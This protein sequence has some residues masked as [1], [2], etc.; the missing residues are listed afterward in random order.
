MPHECENC[1]K[2]F[3]QKSGLTAHLTRIIP[4]K[5]DTSLEVLI[6][7]K[8]K[9]AT[10]PLIKQINELKALLQKKKPRIRIRLSTNIPVN[11]VVQPEPVLVPLTNIMKPF[12]KWVGGKTQILD[13]VLCLYPREIKS[14]HEPFLGG[15]SVLLGLLSQIKSAKI[16]VNGTIYASDLNSNLIALY[17]NIQEHCEELI[18]VLKVRVE[19]FN[20]IN[21]STVN[22]EAKS[23]EE[24]SGSQ[25]SFYYFTRYM[26]NKMTKEERGSIVGSATFIF[27]NKTCFRGVYRES[28]NGGFN[29]PFGHYKN[30]GILDEDHMRQ[31]SSLVKDVVF[32]CQPFADSLAKVGPGDFVYLDPPYAP[33]NDKSFVAYTSDG[34]DLKGHQ[35]LFKGIADLHTKGSKI[36][37]SNADVKLVKEAFPEPVYKTKIVSCRR[38]INSKDPAAKTNEVLIR[39]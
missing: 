27:L 21:G 4:C 24:A 37:M 19:I 1:L 5:K 16:K 14:Y 17:K 10:E 38:A 36:L 39:N 26:F 28:K 2:V 20:K 23:L 22:R 31:V 25:E 9:E 13:D 30:P 3:R 34:F 8:V 15:G 33:E 18:T 7:Q 29:V 32:T 12:L 6:E 11:T 35:S